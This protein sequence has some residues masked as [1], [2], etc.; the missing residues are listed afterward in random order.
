M[1]IAVAAI[2]PIIVI[3]KF[4]SIKLLPGNIITV[5]ARQIPADQVET[6]ISAELLIIQQGFVYKAHV[7]RGPV[8]YGQSWGLYGAVYYHKKSNTW[9]LIYVEPTQH[10]VFSWRMS[11]ITPYADDG[12]FVTVSGAE[13]DSKLYP[14]K[15]HVC[16]AM[17]CL[18]ISQLNSHFEHLDNVPA[19]ICSRTSNL[20]EVLHI[21][22][23]IFFQSLIDTE[24]IVP[25]GN[26]YRL[27]I[28][29]SYLMWRRMQLIQKQ[30]LSE[31]KTLD[32]EALS[33]SMVNV[34]E[35]NA[36]PEG[37]F[38]SYQTYKKIH[39]SNQASGLV[40]TAILFASV[41]LFSLSFGM[42]FSWVTLVLLIVVLFVHEL[43][44]LFGM[45][46]FG[47]KDL[48]M[49]FIPF[50]G[51]LASGKKERVNVWQEA[52][53]LLL[54]PLPGYVL[55]IILIGG[56]FVDT[57]QW[58]VQYGTISLILNAINL[59]PFMPLDG[60]RI[61][62]LA[63]FNRLPSFQLLLT[64]MSIISLGY[65]GIFWG[66]RIALVIAIVLTVSLPY[67]WKEIKLLK[68]LLKQKTHKKSID[69][70]GLIK[71]LNKHPIWI[72]QLPQNRGQLLDS[73]SYRV[74]HAGSGVIST[75]G[76]FVL[77]FSTII[78]PPNLFVT[79]EYVDSLIVKSFEAKYK[80]DEKE[81]ID[82]L[83]SR[84]ASASND[85]VKVD[86]ALKL[87]S[88]LSYDQHEKG[89]TYWN[90]L[91]K[92]LSLGDVQDIKRGEHYFSMSSNC[93]YYESNCEERY[94][95]KSIEWFN[96]ANARSQ[97][98]L[99]L[100]R[101]AG[102]ENEISDNKLAY[103]AQAELISNENS[104]DKEWHSTIYLLRS[105][106]YESSG[107]VI[108][109]EQSLNKAVKASLYS[110]DVSHVSYQLELI[111]FYIRQNEIDKNISIIKHWISDKAYKVNDQ[112]RLQ[113]DLH[114]ILVWL[115]IDHDPAQAKQYLQNIV[116]ANAID[117]VELSIAKAMVD[118]VL[119]ITHSPDQLDQINVL[120]NLVEE[121]FQWGYMADYLTTNNAVYDYNESDKTEDSL[122]TSWYRKMNKIINEP[123]F[124][125]VLTALNNYQN[126]YN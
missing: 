1:L 90:D 59:L 20:S 79:D 100:I 96:S 102:L 95:K 5:D 103:L 119:G 49:L 48:R 23:D 85:E 37:Q 63:L 15:Y 74:Q 124:S 68:Y 69:V 27:T 3:Y 97:M 112:L 39:D 113:D 60:G 43:G 25:Q 77:W 17:T 57:P 22:E 93:I 33:N 11:L 21:S 41:I 121:D 105:E 45:W 58:L 36:S 70:F 44:H 50:M 7:M 19:E 120:V 82:R 92:L 86:S 40:K 114:Y 117:K 108:E 51:A 13:Y 98:I 101:L 26:A 66:E 109:A 123:A 56:I 80:A 16:D 75:F 115:L 8:I 28:V 107:N 54:G 89:L 67:L 62:N 125:S 91:N 76:I 84:Y 52:V 94:L 55:G 42:I 73:L 38:E 29:H 53:I 72:K 99:P 35:L 47:Y 24:F 12:W 78:I 6:L 71:V 10:T 81:E 64:L 106:I 31:K 30:L 61:V 2:I 126:K 111:E 87:S 14:H 32:K 18:P 110:I 4:T 116:P 9:A 88:R 65:V 34:D 46:I 118:E 122:T 83:V 104:T